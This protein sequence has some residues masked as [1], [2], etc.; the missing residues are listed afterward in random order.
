MFPGAFPKKSVEKRKIFTHSFP[1]SVEKNNAHLWKKMKKVRK[2]KEFFQMVVENHVGN[3]DK[4]E[5][6]F[7]QKTVEIF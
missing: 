6:L 1:Q 5:L 2:Y 3:V 7:P 4:K